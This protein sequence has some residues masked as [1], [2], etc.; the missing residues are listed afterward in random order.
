MENQSLYRRA[1]I[2]LWA[3][4]LLNLSIGALYA[5]SVLQSKLTTPL[6]DGGF[7][8]TVS[9]AGLPFSIAI[10]TFATA[11]LIGGRI[12]D[13]IGPRWVIT[14]GSILLGIGLLLSG[15]V[16]N[17]VIGIIL[18]YGVIAAIGMGFC[19]GC[20]TAPAL[21][22]FSPSKKGLVSGIIV[23]G[24][25]LSA[26]GMAP[27]VTS[28][29]DSFGISQTFM[30][31]GV[32]N[33]VISTAIA[34]FIKNPPEGYIPKA[35]D[36]PANTK[37]VPLTASVNFEWIEMLKT[38]RFYMIFLMF[39]LA[40]SVGLMII[41]SI[42]RIAI[43]QAGITESGILA[44]LVSFLAFTN[45]LGRVAGGIMSDK[46][47]RINSLFVIFILQMINMAAF[48]F[49]QSLPALI[50][51]IIVVGFCFGTLLSV[52]PALCADQ[53][54]LK[55]FGLNYGIMFFAWGLSG[56]MTPVIA[57]FLYDTTGTFNITYIICSAM[58]AAMILVNFML[59][60]DIEK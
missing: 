50:L 39:I 1:N 56:V 25:G 22:W 33:L 18:C 29:L 42:S 38:K 41:G 4:A 32:S 30:I 49:Y 26:V 46:I 47:G 13:K 51:G 7:G 19:Y 27:L 21:K 15:F 28:L 9:Q 52:M 53:Y 37:V 2:V 36:K 14:A 43:S 12:Q 48:A 58:M 55:N 40:S 17:S 5:W 8:W 24:F 16:G 3:C 44:G 31:L 57:N 60:K 23:G 11:M 20:A 35:S 6:A 34:Q 54:G 45:T 59:K 10:I